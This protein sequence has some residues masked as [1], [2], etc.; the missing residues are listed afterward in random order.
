MNKAILFASIAALLAINTATAADNFGGLGISFYAGKNGVRVVGVMPNSPAESIGLQSGDVILSAN[1]TELSA[2]EPS[3][4]V[5]YLRG[6]AGS[7]VSLVVE[8]AGKQ[9]SLSAKRAQLSVQSLEPNYIS[10][11]YGKS[12][13][14]TSDEISHLA[15]QNVAEGYQ[16]LGVMQQGVPISTSTENLSA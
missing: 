14:L 1:G 12:R 2:V 5:G 8:R 11:W 7:S 16:F 3:Q 13:G 15:S 9:L 10:S 4:Q 6:T